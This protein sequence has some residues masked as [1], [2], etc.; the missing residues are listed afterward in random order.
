MNF[1]WKEL[2]YEAVFKATT[3]VFSIVD[4]SC[5]VNVK[6]EPLGVI[7][8]I[9][10]SDLANKLTI[11]AILFGNSVILVTNNANQKKQY[12]SII[13]SI[14]VSGTPKGVLTVLDNDDDVMRA[15]GRHKEIKQLF[16]EGGYRNFEPINKILQ[17]YPVLSDW[18]HILCN[19]V[20]KKAVW[21]TVGQSFI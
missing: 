7:A 14:S 15:L 4:V 6:Q 10:E 8:I 1:S 21:T 20:M 13:N 19:V 3:P 12:E 9:A 11:A 16:M 18:D 5:D 17:V 2:I